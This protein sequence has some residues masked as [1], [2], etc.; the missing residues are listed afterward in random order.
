MIEGKLA[1]RAGG[2]EE[3]FDLGFGYEFTFANNTKLIIDYA[4]EL[5]M[6]VEETMG[7]HFVGLSFRFD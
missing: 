2:R 1:I 5:P 3:A 7:S 6:E 4:L